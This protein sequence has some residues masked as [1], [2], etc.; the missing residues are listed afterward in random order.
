MQPE[1]SD[2]MIDSVDAMIDAMTEEEQEMLSEMAE[3]LENME[4]LDPHMSEEELAK[5]KT[6]HRGAENKEIVKADADYW[7]AMMKHNLEKVN[8]LPG[9][10]SH[11]ASLMP[12]MS[13]SISPVGAMPS[14]TDLVMSSF[15]AQA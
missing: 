6:K 4:I 2:D 12:M 3:M 14:A 8:T 1:I 13:V 9:D 7:K 5:L 10:S 15:D 11:T